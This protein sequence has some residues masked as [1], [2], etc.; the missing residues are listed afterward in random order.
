MSRPGR[1]NKSDPRL[2]AISYSIE[3]GDNEKVKQLLLEVGVDAADGYLRTSLLWA[4]FF[5]NITLLNWL[6]DK[7]ANLNHQ[8][9]NG[10]SA[11]HFA[12][13]EKRLACAELLIDKGANLELSNLYGNTPLWTAIFNSRGDTTLVRLFIQQ[14]ANL[15]HLNKNQKTPRQIAEI[16]AGFDLTA[17]EK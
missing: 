6:I 15:D 4:T 5:N 8:D 3:K 17:L 14:G 1:P 10:D 9:R 12:G 11:L 2:D 13:Q 7:G 16:I